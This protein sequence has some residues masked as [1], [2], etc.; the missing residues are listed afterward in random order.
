MD[1][2]AV[3]QTI[4]FIVLM[5]MA[6]VVDCKKH[7]IPDRISLGIAITGLLCFLPGKLLGILAALP[8]LIAAMKGQM[9]GG[10]V[11]LV[12]ACGLVLGLWGTLMGCVIG[13]GILLFL[14]G[15]RCV[16]RRQPKD[17]WHTAYPLAPFLSV[18][19]IFAYILEKGGLY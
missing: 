16:I 15:C 3:V 2:M 7:L 17:R 4:L 18:G 19:F 8:F 5:L 9:G 11:K 14:H 6:A 10:D 13:L 12:A 1:R